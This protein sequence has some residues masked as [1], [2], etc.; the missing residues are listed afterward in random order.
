MYMY[1]YTVCTC[2]D[3]QNTHTYREDMRRWFLGLET[4]LLR[5]RFRVLYREEQKYF[6]SCYKDDFNFE[7]PDINKCEEVSSRWVCPIRP[8]L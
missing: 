8:C 1:T 5:I 7:I 2:A 6:F 4:E 3:T